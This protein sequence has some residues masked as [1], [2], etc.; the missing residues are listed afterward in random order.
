M[1]RLKPGEQLLMP[2]QVDLECH[3]WS[4]L[5]GCILSWSAAAF[6]CLIPTG[7]SC[8][9]GTKGSSAVVV[10]KK[11]LRLSLRLSVHFGSYASIFKLQATAAICAWFKNTNNELKKASLFVF[12]NTWPCTGELKRSEPESFLN[13]FIVGSAADRRSHARLSGPP[14]PSLYVSSA[15]LQSLSGSWCGE[16]FALPLIPLHGEKKKHRYTRAR[17]LTRTP[18]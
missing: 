7:S 18:T 2:N 14:K 13:W 5:F 16:E 10:E 8:R 12:I 6:L 1:S 3:M 4:R 17:T 9:T 15:H 11:A